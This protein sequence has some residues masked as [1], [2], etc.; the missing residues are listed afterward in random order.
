MNE[1]DLDKDA[2]VNSNQI[3]S[4]Q[5]D[6][7]S[8]ELDEMTARHKEAVAA[9]NSQGTFRERLICAAISAIAG[10]GNAEDVAVHAIRIADA[11]VARL[12][13]EE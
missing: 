4:Q 8:Y 9:L 10:T 6:R 2:L 13:E 1:I 5:V 7:L 12:E 11:V 3:L